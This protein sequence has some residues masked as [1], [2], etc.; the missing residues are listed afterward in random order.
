MET[1]LWVLQWVVS[2]VGVGAYLVLV[3]HCFREYGAWKVI[4][5]W[6][7]LSTALHQEGFRNWA[8]F[9]FP[10]GYL[11]FLIFAGSNRWQNLKT[12]LIVFGLCVL[13]ATV[14]Q[15]ARLGNWAW[16]NSVGRAG[17]V[18]TQ[19]GA[20]QADLPTK[21]SAPAAANAGEYKEVVNTIGVQLLLIPAGTFNSGSPASEKDRM[22]DETQHSW[23]DSVEFCKKLS[24]M[25]GKVY[26]LPTEAEWEYA[27][28]GGTK[29][30]FSFGNDKAKLRRYAWYDG[31][32]GWGKKYAQ[33]V[34]Q[35]LPNPFGLYDMHGNVWE[36]CS[37]WFGDYPSTPL[38]D[39]RGPDS[40]SFRV[41]RG[42]SFQHEPYKA[43]CAV[44]NYDAPEGRS[45]DGGFRLV[46]E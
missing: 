6:Y 44:R 2:L 42:G 29:T 24:A 32:L 8:F 30:S 22:D 3:Y 25:E 4:I 41:L 28:R 21:E 10:P 14:F 37:D 7:W 20:T 5:G 45:S 35:K 9:L 43:R 18:V 34:A 33:R 17:A 46:L 15:R 39:P 23:G 1:L 26:R 19:Q 16:P 38:T 40:G 36:W 13:A 12:P 27:C 11:L 31:N